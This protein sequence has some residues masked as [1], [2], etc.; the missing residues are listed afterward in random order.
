MNKIIITIL[1]FI[2]LFGVGRIAAQE[3]SAGDYTDLSKSLPLDST[4]IV[5]K[6]ENGLRYYI[7][8]NHKPEHRAELRLIVNAGSLMEDDDQRGL[9]HVLEHVAFDGTEHFKKHELTNYL[10]SVGMRFGPDINASTGFDETIFMLEIPT[11]SASIVQNAF[12]IL[13]DW[14]HALS[15]DSTEIDKERK[16]V[17]EEWRLGRGADARMRDKQFP[18]LFKN[19]RYAERLPIGDVHTLETFN[20]DLLMKFYHDWYRPDLMAIV[21]V[22]DFDKNVIEKLMREHFTHLINPPNERPRV[23]YPVPDHVDTI[24]AIASDS[25]ATSSEFGIYYKHEIRPQSTH[26]DYRRQLV[27]ALY[28]GIINSR[29]G[30]ISRKPDPP[31][32]YGYSSNG[33]LSRTKETYILGA[34]V[35]DN[36]ILRGMAALLTEAA[37]ARQN[38]V[39]PTELERQKRDFIRSMENAYNERDKTESQS[40]AEECVRNYTSGEPIPGIAYEFELYKAYIP[41]IQLAE[42]DDIASKFISRNNMVLTINQPEKNTIISPAITELKMLLDSI[43]HLTVPAY[44]DTVSDKPLLS[45]QPVPGKIIEQI[46]RTNLGITEW[47]LSNGVRVILKPTDFKN[48]EIDFVSFSPGGTSLAADSD[49]IVA[50][51]AGSII[52]QGGVGNFDLITLSKKLAGKLASATP[53]IGSLE[54][55]ISGNSSVKDAETMFQL[56]YLYFT[57][58]RKD[59]S[60]FLSYQTK[61]KSA[62]ENRSA[63]PESDFEDTLQVTM[64]QHH[65]RRMPWTLDILKKMNLER[66]YSIYKDR[67]ANASDFT[68]IFAGNFN[69]DSLKPLVEKY[70]GGLPSLKRHEHWR[71][72]GVRPPKGVVVKT[73]KR[74]VESKSEVRLIFTGPF[75]WSPMNRFELNALV[76]VLRIKLREALREDKGGTYNV[77]VSGN[78]SLEPIPEYSLSI[79]FGCDPKR[80]DELTKTVLQQ[81]DSVKNF[82]V[83]GSYIEKVKEIQRRERETGLKQNDFWLTF[84]QFYYRY[85]EDPGQILTLEERLKKLTPSMVQAAAK[86][87]F[88]VQNYVKAVLYPQDTK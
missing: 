10:E 63:D 22:G 86:K 17:I 71:D 31:F 5:G 84:L 35:K 77:G 37:R 59:S 67:F 49:Y 40:Y 23:V 75:K 47:K 2:A 27:E 18:L 53:F 58:P 25:E 78:P 64:A 12:R 19:S 44:I 8:T 30:E 7:R 81:I 20:H 79:S 51:T 74:G 82:P 6:L 15:F 41:G 55:G 43:G 83:D 4:L 38:G 62:L 88:N 70:L 9:A 11:D 1:V 72:E 33:T 21:A 65:P 56:V 32:L 46:N 87:Y 14:S 57:A 50:S 69:T 42:V 52:D 54:E 3:N 29:L 36:G 61:M 80:V 28:S 85:N 68:F 45:A 66:S 26:G 16:V 24:F 48:D 34:G 13:E 39:T 60:A 73:V 76:S